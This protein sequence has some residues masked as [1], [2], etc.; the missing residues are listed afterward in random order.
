MATAP[1]RTKAY[2]LKS[3]TSPSWV[4]VELEVGETNLRCLTVDYSAW[5]DEEIGLTDYRAKLS[6]GEPVVVFDF[7]RERLVI[8]WLRQFYRGGFQVSQDDSRRW[9]VT[10]VHPS[11]F[12]SVLD[13][14]TDRAV[15][16][17]WRAALPDTA[18]RD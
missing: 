9:L 11:G 15:W 8:D 18:G 14:M 1:P 6:A 4:D 3:R 12:G 16:R 5:V 2:L 10:L 13:L 7:L 17:R